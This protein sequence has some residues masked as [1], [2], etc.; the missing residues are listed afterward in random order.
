MEMIPVTLHIKLIC[1]VSKADSKAKATKHVTKDIHLQ[2][3]GKQTANK[4]RK[5]CS[6]SLVIIETK[7]K[8]L[9]Y[10]SI[11]IA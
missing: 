4:H 6:T 7:I 3:L 9:K 1:N 10:R 5:K 11:Q 8:V 2:D